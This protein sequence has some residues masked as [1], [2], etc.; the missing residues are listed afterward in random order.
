MG[1]FVCFTFLQNYAK[2]FLQMKFDSLKQR[3]PFSVSHFAAFA[4][5]SHERS[6]FT[7][8][9]IIEA[10]LERRSSV[11][12]QYCNC[13]DAE[14]PVTSSS[15]ESTLFPIFVPREWYGSQFHTL[16]SLWWFSSHLFFPPLQCDQWVGVFCQVSNCCCQTASHMHPIN[17]ID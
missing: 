17:W 14:H 9:L 3:V 15:P 1:D 6:L 4:H 10:L 5:D 8:Q 7:T 16:K 11:W 13:G 12:V 2:R